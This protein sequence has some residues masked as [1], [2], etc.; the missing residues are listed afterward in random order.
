VYTDNAAHNQQRAI[1]LLC[2]SPVQAWKRVACSS[3]GPG[4]AVVAPLGEEQ[5]TQFLKGMQLCSPK[6]EALALLTFCGLALREVAINRLPGH[7]LIEELCM[8]GNPTEYGCYCL[9][10][11]SR[12]IPPGL[13]THEEVKQ[14][15][16]VLGDGVGPSSQPW[17][18]GEE[19]LRRIMSEG[20]MVKPSHQYQQVRQHT[21]SWWWWWPAGV[22]SPEP[23][24]PRAARSPSRA[25]PEPR[26]P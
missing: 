10:L 15:I 1:S 23:R 16:P 6:G 21:S 14:F 3:I 20:E 7:M 4:C 17:P 18:F 24:V 13:L 2:E 11:E 12:V 26:F 5:V 19:S 25:F 8:P 9:T 22:A